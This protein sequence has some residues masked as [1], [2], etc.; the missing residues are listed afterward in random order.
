MRATENQE[1]D[2]PF[3]R[4]LQPQTGV[5][6]MGSEVGWDLA[7]PSTLARHLYAGHN[8]GPDKYALDAN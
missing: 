5:H 2:T 6:S 4:S 8:G 3:S 7:I 1:K